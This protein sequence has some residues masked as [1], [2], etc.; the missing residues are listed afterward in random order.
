MAT[1]TFVNS[2][3]LSDLDVGQWA[4]MVDASIDAESLSL[5]QALG[6]T[7][8][9]RLR[10]CKRG[11]PCVVQVRATRIGISSRIARQI[12]V[13]AEPGESPAIAVA[14]ATESPVLAG[15]R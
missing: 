6:L 9:S 13:V 8:N 3:P 2:R 10:V 15:T 14:K 5:L 1:Q 12:S 4:R 7:D 11:E